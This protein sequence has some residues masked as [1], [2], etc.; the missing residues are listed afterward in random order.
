MV[1]IILILNYFCANH[2]KH[3]HIL[4]NVLYAA[5]KS[6]YLWKK[7]EATGLL[8]SLGLKTPLSNILLIFYF[9]LIYIQYKMNEK[10]NKYIFIGR[11]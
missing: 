3:V 4:F 11:R 1:A 9:V 8:S 5:V 2:Y 6:P 7:Q 10:V